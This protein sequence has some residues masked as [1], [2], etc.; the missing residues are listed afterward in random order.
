ME[1]KE[2]N[3]KIVETY[4][5]EPFWIPENNQLFADDLIVDLPSAPPGMPQHLDAFDARQYREWLN[6][7]V[8]NYKSDLL[9]CYG[10]PDPN[11]FW[12]I[13]L[14][15]CD[16]KWSKEAGEFRS[17]IFT[18]IELKDEKIVYIKNNWNPLA[19]LNAIHADIPI[20]RMDME[21]PRV[22]EF[23]A[24]P[25]S[26]EKEKVEETL[27]TSPEAIK[28]RI[29]K[30][31]DAFRCGDYFWAL[32]NMATF[33]P[34]HDAKVWFLPPEMKESYPQEMMERVEAWT[35][36]SCP[37]ISFDEAGRYWETDDPRVYFCEYM[38][39]G[40]TDWIGNDAPGAHYR[41]RY[42]YVIRFD[43]YGRIACCEEVLNPINK[44]NSIGVS[45]PSFPY[46]F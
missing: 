14:A 4:L 18:R 22:E 29:Q 37:Q 13:R 26:E 7:T 21:D 31:L 6:R 10:T 16:V 39:W 32:E 43:E 41:N 12:A 42:F 24:Q 25:K 36:M 23:L 9:E 27:D 3:R 17:R 40:I 38:C 11:V 5:T 44:F 2:I 28:E 33:V 8:T 15:S 30:N 46:Y 19:F 35:V 34:N 45:I 1:Q 20:F